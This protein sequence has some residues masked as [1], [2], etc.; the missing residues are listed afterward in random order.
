[1]KLPTIRVSPRWAPYVARAAEFSV[2]LVAS[3]AFI[4]GLLGASAFVWFVA[5]R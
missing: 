4:G 2:Y 1:M 5:S 3:G